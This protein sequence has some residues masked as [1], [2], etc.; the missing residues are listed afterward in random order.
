MAL[1]LTPGGCLV[2][3]KSSSATGTTTTASYPGPSVYSIQTLRQYA[4]TK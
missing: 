4:T 2:L 1:G 3:K